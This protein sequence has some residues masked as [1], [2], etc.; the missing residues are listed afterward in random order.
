MF[1]LR[2]GPEQP[3]A[4]RGFAALGGQAHKQT[5][6]RVYEAPNL[7]AG[8]ACLFWLCFDDVRLV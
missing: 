2:H 5:D 8:A 3:V 1:P 7:V 4:P 6:A